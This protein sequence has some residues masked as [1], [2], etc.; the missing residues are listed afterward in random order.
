MKTSIILLL[1]STSLLAQQKAQPTFMG[2]KLGVALEKQSIPACAGGFL[3]NEARCHD[4]GEFIR[5]KGEDARPIT[6]KTTIPGAVWYVEREF[7]GSSQ[8]DILDDLKAKYGKAVCDARV[9]QHTMWSCAW[10]ANWGIVIFLWS[11]DATDG[12]NIHVSGGTKAYYA[13]V[14]AVQ[15][16]ET[17]KRRKEESF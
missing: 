3:P 15:N 14:K 16:D 11:P 12:N 13:V 7:P 17:K 2:V 10:S 6:V 5:W 4:G 1:L 9:S 8:E